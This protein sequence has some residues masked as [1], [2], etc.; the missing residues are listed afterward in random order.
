MLENKEDS[1]SFYLDKEIDSYVDNLSFYLDK[2]IDSY[3]DNLSFYV[4]NFLCCKRKLL[5]TKWL[6]KAWLCG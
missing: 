1:L 6:D 4:D 5:V 3:V 2:E